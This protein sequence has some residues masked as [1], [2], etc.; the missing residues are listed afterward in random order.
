V[1]E[2]V[3]L[4]AA[5]KWTVAPRKYRPIVVTIVADEWP[6]PWI[7]VCCSVFLHTGKRRTGGRSQRERM[8]KGKELR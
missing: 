1:E 5:A 2:I 7:V 4:L 3:A 8:R 6:S